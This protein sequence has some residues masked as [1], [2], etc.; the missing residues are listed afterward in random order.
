M[1]SDVFMFEE[2]QNSLMLESLNLK[3][4]TRENGREYS[5][6]R[7]PAKCYFL[8]FQKPA[9]FC[10]LCRLPKCILFVGR[11]NIEEPWQKVPPFFWGGGQCCKR[12]QVENQGWQCIDAPA[13][14]D[15]CGVASV[16]VLQFTQK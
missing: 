3:R 4:V 6:G 5:I 7:V 11:V 14:N 10:I 8:I 2:S 12:C 15:M 1:C 13:V 16:Q 9:I